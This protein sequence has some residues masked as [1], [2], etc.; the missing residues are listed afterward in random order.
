GPPF[1]AGGAGDA[2]AIQPDGD[3]A[4]RQAR[5]EFSI[6]AADDGGLLGMD[7]AQAVDRLAL[8]IEPDHAPVAVAEAGGDAS[9]GGGAGHAAPDLVGHILDVEGAHRALEAD[10]QFVDLT[11]AQGDDADAGELKALIDGGDVGLVA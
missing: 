7:F 3:G 10:V 4:G 2:V 6:D 1:A 5:E 11:L 8:G 9:A